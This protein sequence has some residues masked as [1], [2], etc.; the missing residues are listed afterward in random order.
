[1]APRKI[2]AGTMRLL[3]HD[4]DTAGW[5]EF[6]GA[7]WDLGV[8]KLHVSH[9]YD[10]WSQTCAIFAELRRRRPDVAFDVVAKLAAPHFDE[11]G[12]D[13]DRLRHRIE[14][15][16]EGLG[17]ETI[18]DLQWMWR[19]GLDDDPSRID[20]M[21]DDAKAIEAE[22]AALKKE[23]AIG[24][25]LCFPYTLDFAL[26]AL[27]TLPLDGLVV[28]RNALE[29]ELDPAI[30]RAH[31]RDLPTLVIR[32]F[33]AGKALDGDVSPTSQF[34]HALDRPG[35]EAAIVSLSRRE[36]AEALIDA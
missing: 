1:M 13:G 16:C 34:S 32:P 33:A 21:R 26:E 36:Q 8:R 12:F 2:I 6:Y 18:A 9:E 19:P 27:D 23:G 22:I 29:T 15:Y 11:D 17:I 31:L 25:F 14:E 3:E 28:Y 10:S 5:G 20:A 30:D 35:V 7:L 4:R 24:R